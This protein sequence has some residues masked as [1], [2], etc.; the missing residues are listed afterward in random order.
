MCK[1]IIGQQIS[2]AAANSVFLKFKKKCNNKINAKTVSK[3]TFNQLKTCGLSRQKALECKN[4]K[5]YKDGWDIAKKTTKR[6][7]QVIEGFNT[8]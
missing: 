2:V 1:S 5:E 8:E 4:S 3:L 7:M 6:H